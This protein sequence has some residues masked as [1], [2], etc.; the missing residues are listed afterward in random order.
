MANITMNKKALEQCTNE[1]QTKVDKMTVAELRK[2]ASKYGVKNAHSYKRPELV[3]KVVAAL[4]SEVV[5]KF[6]AKA[7]AKAEAE[8]KA[9]PTKAPKAPKAPKAEGEK[10]EKRYK[11]NKLHPEAN[12]EQIAEEIIANGF[13]DSDPYKINRKVLIVVMK[14]LHCTKWYRTYDKPTMLAMINEK[15]GQ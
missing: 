11:A 1:I 10:A 12:I 3:E 4:V 9:K 13:D 14:K 6:E 2:L 8:A 5:A 15:L 7:K